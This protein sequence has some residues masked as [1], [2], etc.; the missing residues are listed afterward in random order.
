MNKAHS[1]WHVT[2]LSAMA[3]VG[4]SPSDP[5]NYYAT[6][7]AGQGAGGTTATGGSSSTGGTYSAGGYYT[8][9]VTSAGGA[10]ASGGSGG[11]GTTTAAGGTAT[12][13][14]G[15]LTT[16]GGVAT[17]AGGVAT[18]AGG[19]TTS[20]G[21]VVTTTGGVATST[22][23]VATAAGG[24]AT[25]TGGSSTG[26]CPDD[27][28]ATLDVIS[29]RHVS[30]TCNS[31][32]INGYWYCYDDGSTPG[33]PATEDDLF[34]E[35]NGGMCISGT[36]GGSEDAWGIGIGLS[37][38]DEAAFDASTAGVTG[39]SITLTGDTG[40]LPIR[41]ALTDSATVP[42]G[43]SAPYVEI[44]GPAGAQK[45]VTLNIADTVA[46]DWAGNAG[47]SA[48]PATLYGLQIQIAGDT[49]AAAFDLCVTGVALL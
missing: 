17:S 21:G 41:L 28:P 39:F 6:G 23:G 33:C 36:T 48:N 15:V 37:L 44:V 12:G 40:D 2:A 4:C 30:E 10:T 38:N 49:T 18:S 13:T 22:G 31:A 14:G 19:V 5:A 47:E 1:L 20:T 26:S 3:V 11:S 43:D 25:S 32:G 7:G 9:G 46:P 35:A 27:D 34:D 45:V 16:T 42:A 29:S 24:T 8:G